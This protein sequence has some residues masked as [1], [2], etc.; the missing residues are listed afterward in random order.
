[1][2][3]LSRNL[4]EVFELPDEPHDWLMALWNLIQV[5]DD[6]ADGDQSSREELDCA[7][8]DSL[9]NMPSNPFYQQHSETLLPLLAVAFLKWKASDMAER[10][11]EAD[12]VSFVWRASY[13]DIVLAVVQIVH[14]QQV[15]MHVCRDVMKLYGES[16]SS[17]IAEFERA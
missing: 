10:A 1:M 3:W 15:A 11:G 5:F 2:D 12:E 9:V 17:Y 7:I 14:G 4:R 16:Y 6:M 13:Y 8:L